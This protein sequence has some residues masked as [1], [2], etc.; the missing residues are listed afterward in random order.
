MI[1]TYKGLKKVNNKTIL[2]GKR[3][4]KCSLRLSNSPHSINIGSDVNAIT[5]LQE[6][7]LT[8]SVLCGS[9][10]IT[11]LLV[12]SGANLALLNW[13]NLTAFDIAQRRS[14]FV[15]MQI[16]EQVSFLVVLY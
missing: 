13:R 2:S 16:L 3:L 5:N 9:H 8:L 10:E 11:D 6:T 15:T 12:K 1:L 14:D 4:I 7:P